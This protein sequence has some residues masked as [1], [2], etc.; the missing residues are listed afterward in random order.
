MTPTTELA[1]ALVT[2]INDQEWSP[3]FTAALRWR[4]K[5]E[6]QELENLQVSVVPELLNQTRADRGGH[7]LAESMATIMFHQRV[8]SAEDDVVRPLANLL[9]SLETLLRQPA[10]LKLAGWTFKASTQ[11]YV[12]KHLDDKLVWSGGVVVSYSRGRL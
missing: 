3:S 1:D 5:W 11:S 4:V 8:S 10:N 7:V 2:L 12:R 6:P 9:N